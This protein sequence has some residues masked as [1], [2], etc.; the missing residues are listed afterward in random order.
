MVRSLA[1][2]PYD[3]LIETHYYGEVLIPI[4]FP[5]RRY[6]CTTSITAVRLNDLRDPFRKD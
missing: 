2:V 6:C 4:V 3:L 5:D 1:N